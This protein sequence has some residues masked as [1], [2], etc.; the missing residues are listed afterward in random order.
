MAYSYHPGERAVQERVGV[1]E[2]ADKVGRGAHDYVPPV[3]AAF[4]R[5]QSVLLVAARD[6]QG[7]LWVSPLAG[8]PGFVELPD[9]RRI[10]AQTFFA[11]GDPLANACET[12]ADAGMI[13]IDLARRRRMRANGTAVRAGDAF[14][15]RTERV[16]ANCPKYIHPREWPVTQSGPGS[17]GA[18]LTARQRSWIAGADTFFLGSHAAGYGADCSH[19]GGDPGFIEVLDSK[20]LRW[21]DYPGNPMYATLG[22]LA[23]DP[24]AAPP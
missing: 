23:I 13:A 17:S 22:N 3:A 16:F 12:P 9:E 6:P 15:L 24:G 20:T 21:P 11:E 18:E 8:E 14:V 1:L 19:R 4:L 5:E 7:L 2:R 10:V